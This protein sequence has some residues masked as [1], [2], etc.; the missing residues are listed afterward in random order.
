MQSRTKAF[1]Y[2]H[3]SVF[4]FG[5]TAILGDLM[6]VNYISV[7]W[8]RAL[9]SSAML[10]FIFKISRL[11]DVLSPK[12]IFRHVLIGI[13]LAIH[14]LFF[15]GSIKISNATI[16]L[17]ALSSSSLI[18]SILEPLVIRSSKW[19][20][21]DIILGI[22]II[23]GFFMIAYHSNQLQQTGLLVGFG[24]TLLGAFFSILNKKWLVRGQE[25]K[26]TFIQMLSVLATISLF[27]MVFTGF[28]S[29]KYEMLRGND[30]FYMIVFSF[31]CT[32]I[33]YY[34]YLKS[35][36][37]I[38]AFDVSVAFNLEPIYGIIM[39]AFILHDYENLSPIVY[40][41]M[42]YISV[43]VLLNTYLKAKKEK[44][45]DETDTIKIIIKHTAE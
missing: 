44:K 1:I 16:A 17:I 28:L 8:W 15:Y 41:G 36:N 27:F 4:L 42:V 39:A 29:I 38:S 43:I 32:V 31:L 13:L 12:D 7:V 2:L 6:S 14:W 20:Y 40:L 19:R 26:L 23:P 34:L 24:A 11:F 45:T 18:T 33:A 5:F 9:F 25:F 37:Y 3:I 21:Y 10:I 30:W 22:M 35:M